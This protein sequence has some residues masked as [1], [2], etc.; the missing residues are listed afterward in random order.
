MTSPNNTERAVNTI[1]S[2]GFY[3]DPDGFRE[4]YMDNQYSIFCSRI[5]CNVEDA[6]YESSL[7]YYLY[8]Y[9][10]LTSVYN[11]YY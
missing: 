5:A 1:V 6:I 9:K 8:K 10:T 7:W 4:L 2:T 3:E 11:E